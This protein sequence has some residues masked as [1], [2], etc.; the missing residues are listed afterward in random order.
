[1]KH[2][3]PRNELVVLETVRDA[4]EVLVEVPHSHRRGAGG[5]I[6][7]YLRL[8]RYSDIVGV[9]RRLRSMA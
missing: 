4:R 2:F 5:G 9:F 1:M 3:E 7:Y 8:L 6:I